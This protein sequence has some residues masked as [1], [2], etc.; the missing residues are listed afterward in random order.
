[1]NIAVIIPAYKVKQFIIPL[2]EQIDASVKR[3]FVVDDKCPEF[4][5]EFVKKNCNDSRVI[6]IQHDVNLGVGGALI[7]GYKAFLAEETLDVAVKLDG[8]GQ[9]DP[10]LITALVRPII[11]GEA[12]YAKGNR[13]FDLSTV[14]SMPGIRLFGNS[15]LSLINKFVNGYWHIMD[16]TNGFTAI[17]RNE[18]KRIDLSKIDNSY[19]F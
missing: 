7:T 11:N 2:I 13:F 8:D 5:G 14:Q 6:V 4:S 12:D 9:M 3:I 10:F 18:L 15:M 16:P 19:F 1:M 17:N